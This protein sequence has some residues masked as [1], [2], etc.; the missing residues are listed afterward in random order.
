MLVKTDSG[1]PAP[2][3]NEHLDGD[4]YDRCPTHGGEVVEAQFKAGGVDTKGEEYRDWSIFN[5]DL[6]TG[7]C[8][9]SW[10]RTTAT[11]A[12]RDHNLGRE[13]VQLTKGATR[14]IHLA[15]QSDAYADG[16]RRAFGHD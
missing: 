14:S 12:V 5:S 3:A 9:D 10:A 7:G 8:G 16:Y 13:P 11:G 1:A 2:A 15:P 4:Y 6:R